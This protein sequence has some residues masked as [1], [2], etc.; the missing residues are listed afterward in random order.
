MKFHWNIC[1]IMNHKGE[2]LKANL[3]IL[4]GQSNMDGQGLVS[5]LPDCLTEIKNNAWIYSPNHRDDQQPIDDRGFW[6]LLRPGY[7]DGYHTDGERIFLSDRFGPELSYAERMGK[8]NPEA[9]ILIYK[10]AKGGSSI[11]SDA[12]T[13]WG[14][15]DPDYDQGNGINQWTHFRHHLHRAIELAE[16]EFGCVTPAGIVWHQGE[17]DASHTRSIAE[18]YQENLSK[19]LNGI[20]REVGDSTLP[21]VVGQIS[22]SMLG[23]G[24]RKNTYPFG[25]IVK[26][27]QQKCAEEDSH[28][29]LVTTPENHS[30]SDAWHYDSQTYIELGYRFAN[31][32][33]DLRRSLYQHQDANH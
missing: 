10:Y 26:S 1:V 19:V 29:E 20:R 7:G 30:F 21:V 6:D 18:A 12:A 2:Q 31:A 8:F 17:S 15:W 13:D 11:H 3:Y 28:A 5:D 27:A 22:D 9:K 33:M 16:K 14:C 4:A 24:K 23:R 25:D 32:M